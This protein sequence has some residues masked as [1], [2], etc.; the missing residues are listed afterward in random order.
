MHP[1]LAENEVAG[2][3][4]DQ[5]ACLQVWQVQSAHRQF[6][7]ESLHAL[8]EH[9][10]WLQVAQVQLSQTHAAQMSPQLEQAQ[11]AHSS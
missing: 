11:R 2:C 10:L 8:Q 4:P 6:A 7:H 1:E 9:V 5:A 3:P